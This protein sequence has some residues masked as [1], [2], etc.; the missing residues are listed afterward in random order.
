MNMP[1]LSTAA[2]EIVDWLG[3]VGSRWGLPKEACRVHGVMFLLARPVTDEY[4]GSVLQLSPLHVQDALS[5][6]ATEGLITHHDTG[7]STETDPWLLLTQALEMRRI[8]ELEPAI[9]VLG[10]WQN[11]H[12]GEDPKVIRQANQLISLIEDIAAI[13]TTARHISPTMMRRF[14]SVSGRAARIMNRG[15]GRGRMKG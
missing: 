1:T 2:L 10:F 14:L 11:N 7:W 13:D 3:M 15:F 6:L 12:A 9:Q 4:L 8:R 5:W